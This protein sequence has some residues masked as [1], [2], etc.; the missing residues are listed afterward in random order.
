MLRTLCR[1]VLALCL[2]TTAFHAF[3]QSA[4]ISGEVADSQGG[5][6]PGAEVKIVH[7]TQGTTR[8]TH[9]NASGYYNAPFLNSGSYR[10]YVQAK[11]FGIAA[12]DSI[13]L[14]V[15]QAL[16]FNVQLKPGSTAQTVNVNGGEGL[17]NT[18][19]AE[20]GQVIG[21]SAIKDLPLNGRDPSSLVFLSPGVTN[22]LESHAATL[23]TTNSFPT[24]SGASAGGGRQGST[25]YLLDGV[26]NMDTFAMLAAPFPNADA[27]QEFRVISNNFD[28]RY[29]FAPNA[30]V[31]IQTKAG[32]NEF[33]GGAFEFIRNSD[34][35]ASNYFTHLVDPLKRNQFGVYVGGP[36]LRDRLFFFANYQGTRTSEASSSNVAYTPTSAMLQGD[37]SALPVTLPAPFTTV[38][39]K[40]NQVAPSLFS[41]GAVALA[42]SLPLGGDPAT[43]LTNF[44]NPATT[45]NYD[46]GTAR[47]DYTINDKQRVFLRNFLYNY[48]QP[49][50]TIP[51]NII[52]GVQG[53][54]GSYVNEV[55]NHTWVISPSLINSASLSYASIDYGTG[56]VERDAN[57]NAICLS[58]FISVSDPVNACYLRR[59]ERLRRKHLVRRRPGVLG[60]FRKSK[61]YQEKRLVVHRNDHQDIWEA[62]F[63]R[64]S[65]LAPPLRARELWF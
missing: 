39:G 35:N 57:G 16:V 13:T 48:D 44:A 14:S 30:V 63:C 52:A 23:P 3:A 65:R 61:R 34:L 9:T 5:V 21:E 64:G 18:S 43:G 26:S 41:P 24:E 42:K 4:A 10:I 11:D 62:C 27:T 46:E 33:H 29:G 36:I 51:G 49:G 25:W 38:N 45:A 12:S 55:V 8:T 58:Q 60:F 7:Q 1:Y 32:S 47:L 40:R 2:C 31:S 20:I 50:A 54:H 19:T 37:F 59:P 28:A 15:G 6:I 56:T 53:Q 17:I 22:E